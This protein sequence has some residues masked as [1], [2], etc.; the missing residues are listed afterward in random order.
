MP[1][2]ACQ[3]NNFIGTG[4]NYLIPVEF[5]RASFSDNFYYIIITSFAVFIG[6]MV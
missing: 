6:V 2:N 1:L 3:Q 4:Y 5:S